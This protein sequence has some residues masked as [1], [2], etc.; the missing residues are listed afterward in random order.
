[1]LPHD[2][3]GTGPAVVLLH[4]GVCDRRMWAGHLTPL[5][6][7]GFRAI[8]VDLPGFG[9]APEG[10]GESAPWM[11]VHMTLN[12]LGIERAALVGNS[13]GG[14]VAMRF[15]ALAP[16]RVWA[17]VAISAPPPDLD[18]SPRLRAAWDA[19]GEAIDRGDV[20]GAV[21]AVVDAWTQPDAPAELRELVAAMQ[22]RALQLQMAA[23]E[24]AQ[25]PDPIGGLEGLTSIDVPALIVAGARDMPDFV[26]SAG[27]MVGALPRARYEAIAAAGHLAPL[28]TPDEFR[29]LLLAFLR[30]NAP[31]G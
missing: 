30:E 12:E 18:P 9:D 11:D 19:E 23:P 27:R 3:V 7:A 13:L 20:E 28:E 26:E 10:E 21:Q 4:A 17:L 15:A 16:A 31:A 22:R 6:E 1:M 29:E 8:A 2:D 5:A 25:A 14:A 24:P